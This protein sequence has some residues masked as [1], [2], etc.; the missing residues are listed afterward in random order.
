[1]ECACYLTDKGVRHLKQQVSPGVVAV[2][3][4]VAVIIAGFFIWRGMKGDVGSKPPGAVGNP[5]PF[6]P[7]GA[8]LG[9]QGAARPGR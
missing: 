2:V 5:S 7:G 3:I 9:K 4:I 8:A 6:A 1:M